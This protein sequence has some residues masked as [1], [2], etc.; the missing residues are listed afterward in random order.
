MG[1]DAD[2]DRP[3]APRGL[4]SIEQLTRYLRL[5][6]ICPDVVLCSSARRT[7]ETLDGISAGLSGEPEVAIETALYC[8][9]KQQL[10]DRVRDLPAYADGAMVIGHNPGLRS[11]TKL[12]ISTL[13]KSSIAKIKVGNLNNFQ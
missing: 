4:V 8:A 13:H 12:E 6:G 9:S 3:L 10:L 5:Q 7:R 2:H 11:C 1:I